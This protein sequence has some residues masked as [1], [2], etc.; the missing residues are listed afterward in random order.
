MTSRNDTPTLAHCAC[1]IQRG[2]ETTVGIA[3]GCSTETKHRAAAASHRGVPARTWLYAAGSFWRQTR[4]VSLGQYCHSLGLLCCLSSCVRRLHCIWKVSPQGYHVI[5]LSALLSRCLG[6]IEDYVRREVLPLYGNTH[7]AS[8]YTSRQ[9]G[10][11]REEA[12]SELESGRYHS[13]LYTVYTT[14]ENDPLKRTL[15]FNLRPYV[16]LCL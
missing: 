8:S 11:F 7:S 2:E 5:Q 6:F 3:H 13:G 10:H 14:S 1:A 9:T 16:Y 15:D 4:S 12:R